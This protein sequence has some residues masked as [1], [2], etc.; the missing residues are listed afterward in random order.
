[1]GVGGL[2]LRAARSI[3][4]AVRAVANTWARWVSAAA[5]VWLMAAPAVFG[6]GGLPS[7][8]HRVVGPVAAA[9]AFVAV[10]QFLRPLRWLNLVF[11]GLLLVAPW[12]LAFGPAATANSLVVGLVLVSLA[13]VRGPGAARFGGG[14][15][16]L[17]TGELPP[18]RDYEEPG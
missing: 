14:W 15:S 5:G 9:F 10:W 11:G 2:L 6:Y 4:R 18:D 13:F 17:W 7:A 3:G 1:M 12:P 8:F 16:A